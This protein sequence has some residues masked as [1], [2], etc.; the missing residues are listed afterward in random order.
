VAAIFPEHFQSFA[1]KL[2]IT[3]FTDS[4]APNHLGCLLNHKKRKRRILAKMNQQEATKAGS[5]S[6]LRAGRT[7]K[8]IMSYG[9]FRKKTVYV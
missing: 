7:V 2:K 3:F 6:V 1:V 8:E 9:D 4:F 5:L